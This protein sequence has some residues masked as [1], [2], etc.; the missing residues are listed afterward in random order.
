MRV[1]VLLIL[2]GVIVG[3][4]EPRRPEPSAR[5]SLKRIDG[6]TFE[7]VPAD[8]QYPY[9][10]VFTLSANGVIRQLTMS[11]EN[12]SF[13]CPAQKPIGAHSYRVPLDEGT[14]KV[15]VLFSSQKVN[16]A[17]VAQQLLDLRE[18]AQVLPTDLR[19][20]GNAAIE[21]IEFA[22]VAEAA[23]TMGAIVGVSD[24]GTP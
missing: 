23:P 19:L 1:G 18:R 6:T 15:Q 16:A 11:R 10:L 13:A 4:S 5:A 17:S 22:A 12:V 9:C 21:T 24:A 20:P 7:L 14:V 3:C 2:I 8:G